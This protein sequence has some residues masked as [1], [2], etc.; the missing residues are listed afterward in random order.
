MPIN[1]IVYQP[2]S[3]GHTLKVLVSR[4]ELCLE[5]LNAGDKY[6]FKLMYKQY[7]ALLYGAILAKTVD[8]NRASVILEQTFIM[9]WETISTFDESKCKLFTW[10]QRIAKIES[11]KFINS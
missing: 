11:Q 9:A 7:S 8:E 2:N 6:M 3:E 1:N 10:L 4:K 5:E